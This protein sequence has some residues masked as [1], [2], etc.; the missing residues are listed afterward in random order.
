MESVAEPQSEP[1]DWANR[2]RLKYYRYRA[3][4]KRYWWILAL[5]IS[6]GLAYEAWVLL[7]KDVL[8]ESVGSFTLSYRVDIPEGAQ[9]V[10]D[11]RN[12]YGT[13]LQMLQYPE[14]QE[15][16]R[17]RLS[18]EAPNLSGEVEISAMVIPRTSIFS[19]IGQG[20]H[21]EYT[22]RFVDGV[23]QEFI[24]YRSERRRDSADNTM[25][26][27]SEE[28][29]RLRRDL[30]VRE[31]ELTRFIEA[32]N[33][34]FWEDQG[35]TAAQYLSSLKTQQA[36]LITERHRLENLTAD[37]LLSNPSPAQQ[38]QPPDGKVQEHSVPIGSDLNAQYLQ[39]SQDLIQKRAE[40]EGMTA[41]YKDKHPKLIAARQQIEDLERL[42]RTIREQNREG[43]QARLST[44]DAELK[45]IDQ[46]IK[47]WEEKVLAASQK[48]AEFRR[49]QAGVERTQGLYEKLLTSV[50]TLDVGKNLNQEDLQIIQKA[51]PAQEVPAGTFKHL[52]IGLLLGCA[53]GGGILMLLDRTDD[54]LTS[55]S[56]VLA[57]FSEPILAQIPDVRSGGKNA[58]VPLLQAEDTRYAF[59]ESFRSLRSSLIFMPNQGELKTLVVTSS[60]PG[61]GKSTVA[62]NLAAT[63]ALAGAQVLLVDADLRR[64][65]LGE[66]F[67]ADDHLGF[68]NVLRSE[69]EWRSVIQTT[70]YPTLHL[71]PSGPVTIQSA[72]LLLVPQIEAL[73]EEF[74][75]CYDLTIFN[76][77]PILATD[78]TATLAPNFDGALMVIR[79]KVTSARFVHNSLTALYA[80]QV[81][82]LGLI[83]NCIDPEA[84]DYYYY[85]YPKYYAA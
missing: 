69:L 32:N 4:I 43:T 19:V 41:V 80:R 63:M 58:R 24:N 74:R 33:M 15:R 20:T 79:S 38:S 77:S 46:S 67:G 26:E 9:Y 21:P 75:N 27:I 56:E 7:N 78:D 11:Q 3:L 22:Q 48:D 49:L 39:A 81:N 31:K 57:S 65:D 76:T 55:S 45:G 10:E 60:I 47:V 34:A 18:L 72:E 70:S 35:K 71:L 5:T 13:Q 29:V 62:S 40:V 50:Q 85:R 28:L 59:A 2:F 25:G 68:S 12:F 61:E 36:A 23:M 17:R 54:R 84:P 64:G 37:Q 30:D 1:R 52:L 53:V 16:A 8:Y 51:T 82:V 83:L 6:V 73:L 14:I 42:I 44:I 66:V